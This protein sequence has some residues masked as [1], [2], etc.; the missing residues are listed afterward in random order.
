MATLLWGHP[1]QW[2]GFCRGIWEEILTKNT[3]RRMCCRRGKAGVRDDPC[4]VEVICP[5]DKHR[6]IISASTA[7]EALPFIF[8]KKEMEEGGNLCS[9]KLQ[10]RAATCGRAR[11]S[12]WP[13][14]THC[15]NARPGKLPTLRPPPAAAWRDSQG[16]GRRAA[17]GG[18]RAAGATVAKWQPTP[19]K[20][21]FANP[22]RRPQ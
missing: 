22:C 20:F 3:S 1:P 9:Q 21:T 4:G 17:G 5:V 10:G 7:R 16:G 11:L 2:G 6:L 13:V 18:R 15:G 14:C 8:T 19:R 12:S